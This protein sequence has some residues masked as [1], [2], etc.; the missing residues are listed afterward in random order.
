MALA[1]AKVSNRVIN[2]VACELNIV[3]GVGSTDYEKVICALYA[4]IT[5]K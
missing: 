1:E 2:L 5:R 3:V 4:E